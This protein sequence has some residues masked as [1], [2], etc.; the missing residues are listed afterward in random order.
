[1]DFT[2]WIVG[3]WLWSGNGY[4]VF[5]KKKDLSWYLVNQI[6]KACTES[7]NTLLFALPWHKKVPCLFRGL[8]MFWCATFAC[9][10]DHV[11]LRRNIQTQTPINVFVMKWSPYLCLWELPQ[12]KNWTQIIFFRLVLL[13]APRVQSLA[14]RAGVLPCCS[15]ATLLISGC[16]SHNSHCWAAWD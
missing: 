10:S 13:A 15:C 16:S 1:M 2:D 14:V 9:N 6:C 7:S 3:M 5:R 8:E 12:G 4:H 11:L